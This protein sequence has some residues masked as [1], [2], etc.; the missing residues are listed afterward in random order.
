MRPQH[1]T[2][3]QKYK[4]KSRPTTALVAVVFVFLLDALT[5]RLLEFRFGCHTTGELARAA[6]LRREEILKCLSFIKAA[7]SLPTCLQELRRC[8]DLFYPIMRIYINSYPT[9]AC[10]SISC[11]P[12]SQLGI[13]IISHFHAT[14]SS[15]SKNP[16][17]LS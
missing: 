7:F 2:M 11:N 4:Y 8:N 13:P 12:P 17:R 6:T 1:E 10:V 5:K 16:W 9:Q 14:I 3:T 15:N